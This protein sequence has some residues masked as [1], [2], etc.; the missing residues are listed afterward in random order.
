MEM[1]NEGPL[2]KPRHPGKNQ[3]NL[4]PQKKKKRDGSEKKVCK[5]ATKQALLERRERESQE[6]ITVRG[7]GVEGET[8]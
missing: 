5:G 6:R 1:T 7:D 3:R 2:S 8:S 4:D